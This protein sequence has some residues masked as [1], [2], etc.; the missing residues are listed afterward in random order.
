M[1]PHIS[2]PDTPILNAAPEHRV[3][4]PGRCL[5]VSELRS[6]RQGHTHHHQSHSASFF[7]PRVSPE[8]YHN[9][10]LS[11]QLFSI[12]G[13]SPF[14]VVAMAP[15]SAIVTPIEVRLTTRL[16]IRQT[17]QPVVVTLTETREFT[18]YTST[19]TLGTDTVFPASPT[20]A[21]TTASAPITVQTLAPAKS[22][23]DNNGVVIGAVLGTFLGLAVLLALVWK[24][25]FDGR[26]VIAR[27]S[28][29]DDDSSYGSESL[30]SS[31]SSRRKVRR[32][33]GDLYGLK[34][35]RKAYVR[36]RRGDGSYDGE[37]EGWR[38]E[39]RRSRTGPV[40]RDG[41]PGW[42]FAPVRGGRRKSSSRRRDSWVESETVRM[43]FTVDD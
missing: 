37:S 39:K 17:A 35:P 23:T 11:F 33:G 19:I 15:V 29:Y 5:D 21:P 20:T 34:R 42:T 2:P 9:F 16:E 12:R 41:M 4:T 7:N 25:C 31:R 24:C 30:G 10:S 38:D 13:Q 14:I 3:E 1:Q 40:V 8:P 6:R 27:P 28:G 18:T 43:R 26:S 22:S 32:R 36:Y